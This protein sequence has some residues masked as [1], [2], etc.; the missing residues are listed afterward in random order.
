MVKMFIELVPA[1]LSLSIT[2]LPPEKEQS[3]L[4]NVNYIVC[5]KARIMIH[6]N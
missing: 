2:V 6:D 1:I 5:N 3:T 4:K